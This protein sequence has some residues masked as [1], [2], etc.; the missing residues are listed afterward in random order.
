MDEIAALKFILLER[1]RA[2]TALVALANGGINDV[3]P[4]EVG[5]RVSPY[6]RFGQ[7][8]SSDDGPECFETYDI[9]GQVDVYS[10]GAGEAASTMESLRIA[11]LVKAV[12]R[13]ISSEIE[14]GEID[15]QNGHKLT[16]IRFRSQRSITASD[17]VTKHVPITITAIVDKT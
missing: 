17:G 9:V 12:I 3:P 4:A 14:A 7:F 1:L 13:E 5:E 11:A 15:L 6:V 10:W 8:T 2:N 16:D